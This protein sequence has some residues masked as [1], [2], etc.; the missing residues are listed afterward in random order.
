MNLA[1]L[2]KNSSIR[3]RLVLLTIIPIIMA[4]IMIGILTMQFGIIKTAN[5]DYNIIQEEITGLVQTTVY[6][7][8]GIL[9]AMN[10]GYYGNISQ[11]DMRKRLSDVRN[12]IASGWSTYLKVSKADGANHNTAVL[13]KADEYI[14]DTINNLDIVIAIVDKNLPFKEFQL[15][16]DPTFVPLYESTGFAAE[17]TDIL[18]KEL[19]QHQDEVFAPAEA[20]LPFVLKVITYGGAVAFL[21][22]LSLSIAITKSITNPLSQ[23][24]EKIT[25]LSNTKDLTVD[26]A[27]DSNNELGQISTAMHDLV[28]N[29]RTSLVSITTASNEVTQAA[30]HLSGIA[31][32]TISNVEQTRAQ[33]QQT[34]AAITQLTAS[35]AEVAE[36]CQLA[37]ST[38]TETN[39]HATHGAHVAEASLN[40]ISQLSDSLTTTS[41]QVDELNDRANEIGNVVNVINDIAD[42]TNLLA[43]NAAIEAARAGDQ[44][45]GFAVVADE[46][47][48]LSQRTQDSTKEIASV[49]SKLQQSANTSSQMMVDGI[50]QA[51]ECM[52]EVENNKQALNDICNSMGMVNDMN[53]QIASAAEE[54][55]AVAVQIHQGAEDVNNIASKSADDADAISAASTQLSGVS[56]KLTEQVSQFTI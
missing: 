42:Q 6:T 13:N 1:S 27:S 9:S 14:N 33:S 3:S 36:N 51:G 31:S 38:T 30:E 41:Q 53:T 37:Q 39:E 4:S 21:I 56:T 54:Q 34:A 26:F 16:M 44:G 22:V 20:A 11:I 24:R 12:T 40:K 28:S 48:I 55:S 52:D 50:K 2:F 46:V 49:I 35:V 23:L 5:N 18:I 25:Q 45:R 15:E 8:R 47:R 29:I 7:P 17:Q 19:K 10:K 43:L 32:T